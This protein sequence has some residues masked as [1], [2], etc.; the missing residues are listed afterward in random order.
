MLVFHYVQTATK[1]RLQQAATIKRC[2]K[3]PDRY[4]LSFHRHPL[5]RSSLKFYFPYRRPNIFPS[6]IFSNNLRF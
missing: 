6:F 4:M 2:L 1:I 3:L 5:G